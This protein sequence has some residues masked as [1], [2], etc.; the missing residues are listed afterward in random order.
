M[1]RNFEPMRKQLEAWRRSELT[2]VT[3]KVVIFE[4]FV[5]GK[6][7]APKTSGPDGARSLLRAKV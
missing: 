2:G 1:Q 3:A 4:A 7:E 5:E 6:L